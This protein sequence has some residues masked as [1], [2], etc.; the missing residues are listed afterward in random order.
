M[1]LCCFA[2]NRFYFLFLILDHPYVQ[3]DPESGFLEV[4]LA[5]EVKMSCKTGGVPKPI[6]TWKHNVHIIENLKIVI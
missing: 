3:P 5:E 6:V 1:L 4:K 2:S